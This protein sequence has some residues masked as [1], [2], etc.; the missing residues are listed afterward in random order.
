MIKAILLTSLFW[1]QLAMAEDNWGV[2]K[3]DL[4][5][6]GCS[7]S[8]TDGETH[9]CLAKQGRHKIS[10]ECWAYNEK[11]EDHK[12]NPPPETKKRK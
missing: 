9:E 10:K 12:K 7:K 6:T 5:T 4:E 8:T 3:V 2:C 11:V 1:S